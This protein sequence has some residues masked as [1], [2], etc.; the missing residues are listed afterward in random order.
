MKVCFLLND[1]QLSGGVGVVLEHARQLSVRHGFDVTVAVTSDA[2]DGWPYRGLDRMR[3]ADATE[4][5]RDAYDVVIATWWETAFHLFDF[6]SSRYAYFVQNLEDRF[7]RP[8]DVERSLAAITHDLPVSFITESRWI[9]D[10]LRELRP[11]AST[12]LVRNGVAKDVFRPADAVSPRRG[13]LN[14]LVEGHPDVWFKGIDDAVATLHQ[15]T[16][17]L[18]TTFVTPSR[19]EEGRLPGGQVGPLTHAGL[20]DLYAETDVVLKLSRVEGMFGPP[21]EGFHLGATCVVWPV[22]GHEE[23]VMHGWNGVVVDWD[24]VR[25]TARW[26]DLLSK[27]GRLLHFLRSNALA[28]AKSWPSWSQSSDFMASALRSIVREPAPPSYAGQRRLLR[29]SRAHAEELR[30]EANFLRS[31]ADWADEQLEATRQDLARKTRAHRELSESTAYKV[32]A[33]LRDVWRHPL[34]RALTAPL[35]FVHWLRRRTRRA[36]GEKTNG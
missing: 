3:V 24:D 32:G 31:R 22:T 34:V 14:V 25:G 13:P 30:R 7:Y 16:E 10:M 2:D 33:R 12:F 20:A 35:R 28:T 21:L 4:A 36:Q 15:A 6:S 27:N 5:A 1:L 17:P 11:E 8:G 19:I 26:L 23:Y 9:A 29:E 18:A